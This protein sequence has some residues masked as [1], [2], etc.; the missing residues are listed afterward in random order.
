[1]QVAIDSFFKDKSTCDYI[2]ENIN[3]FSRLVFSKKYDKVTFLGK[4]MNCDNWHTMDTDKMFCGCIFLACTG[5]PGCNAPNRVCRMKASTKLPIVKE[6]K[7]K[8]T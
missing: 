8:R 6:G 1:M 5:M 4:T 7:M 3:S 2:C